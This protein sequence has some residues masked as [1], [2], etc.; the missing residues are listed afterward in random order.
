MDA[1]AFDGA[2]LATF[3]PQAF[4][5]EGQCDAVTAA[6]ASV[7]GRWLAL[8]DPSSPCT[9]P[10]ST[11]KTLVFLCNGRTGKVEFALRTCGRLQPLQ[12]SFVASTDSIAILTDDSVLTFITVPTAQVTSQLALQ[13]PA[14]SFAL[15]RRANYAVSVTTKGILTLYDLAVASASQHALNINAFPVE[16]VL[17]EDLQPESQQPCGNTGHVLAPIE[18][19]SHNS[20]RQGSPRQSALT[21]PGISNT[22]FSRTRLRKLLNTHGEYPHQYRLLIWEFLLQLPAADAAFSTLRNLGKHPSTGELLHQCVAIICFVPHKRSA[23]CSCADTQT[24]PGLHVIIHCILLSPQIGL[25][26]RACC[27]LVP[28]SCVCLCCC[29]VGFHSSIHRQ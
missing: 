14:V 10:S 24:I 16:R 1:Y 28:K 3:Q 25:H 5:K 6:A 27:H 18:P 9:G 15:D 23:C 20:Q 11:I 12:M 4:C 29:T 17:P 8:T 13:G 26:V 7:D 2:P 22:D 19:T 21:L